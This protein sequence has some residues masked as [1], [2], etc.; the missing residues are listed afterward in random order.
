MGNLCSTLIQVDILPS[1]RKHGVGNEDII[2]AFENCIGWVEA[3][4]DPLRYLLAGPDRAGILIEL[5]VV[6]V[7]NTESIIH[8]MS[9]R[10]NTEVQIFGGRH[11]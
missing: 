6:V 9:L 10:P 2:H 8:A 3:A 5:V 1:A 11:E 7:E 4:D